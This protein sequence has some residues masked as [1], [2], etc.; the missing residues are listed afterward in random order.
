[1]KAVMRR[2]L[3][4]AARVRDFLRAH[5]TE[6]QSEASAL[7]RLEELLQRAQELDAQQQNGLVATHAAA[8]KRDELRRTLQRTLLKFLAGVA[9]VAAKANTDLLVQVRLPR[10]AASNPAFLSAA[11]RILTKATVEKDLLV[12]Q[13]LSASL[14]DDMATTLSGF[15]QTLESTRAGRRDHTGASADLRR[16]DTEIGEQVRLLDGLVRYRFGGD[17]ELMGA[18]NSARNVVGPSKS[19]TQPNA[20]TPETPTEVQ[21]NVVRPAA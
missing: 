16:V 2:R 14:F 19:H 9:A 21:P 20:G 4:M 8:L 6:V 7:T 18:W 1:M 3:E 13:G 10:H 15:E 11:R 12:G 17:A 5:E